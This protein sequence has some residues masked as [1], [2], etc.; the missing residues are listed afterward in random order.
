M[1]NRQHLDSDLITAILTRL[2]VT[3]Q[4]PDRNLLE[5]LVGA[6]V[7][8]IPWESAFRIVRRRHCG[9]LDSCARWPEIFWR[10]HLDSGSG[11]TCFESNLAFTALLDEFGFEYYLTIND[12][13]E[14]RGCHTAIIVLLEE[15]KWLVDVGF[16]FYTILPVSP[17]GKVFCSSKYMRYSIEPL[18]KDRYLI[19]RRPHPKRYAFTLIDQPV[20]DTE[21]RR[22][23]AA[24]YGPDGHFLN[25]VIIHKAIEDLVWRFNSEAWPLCLEYFQDGMHGEYLLKEDVAKQL[26]EKF[27][28]DEAVL[29]EA[30]SQIHS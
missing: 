22:A 1:T 27:D 12:M 5:E 4:S 10:E 29:R 17:W 21:Y 20:S 11:G 3:N 23:T 30:L 9:E 6:Y 18:G 24:D 28:M 8:H 16:P 13:G 15:R 2:Q 19:E 26:S 25:R 14:S 7:R